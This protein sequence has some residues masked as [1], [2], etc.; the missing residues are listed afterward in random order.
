LEQPRRAGGA[1]R[2]S[3]RQSPLHLSGEL[4]QIEA[5]LAPHE[6]EIGKL[7]MRISSQAKYGAM[8]NRISASGTA[9]NRV[10]PGRSDGFTAGAVAETKHSLG[11]S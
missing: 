5:I 9:R 11:G 2:R 6:P 4:A 10:P 7:K 1:K 3:A 8:E